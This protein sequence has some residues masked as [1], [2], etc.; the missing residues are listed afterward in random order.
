MGVNYCL[1]LIKAFIFAGRVM[2]Q[3]NRDK[4]LSFGFISPVEN[5]EAARARLRNASQS[6]PGTSGQWV[7]WRL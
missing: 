4:L 5:L 6:S 3:G 1:F 7:F 2:I